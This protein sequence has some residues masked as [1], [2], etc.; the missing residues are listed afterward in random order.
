MKIKKGDNVILIA[1]KDQGKTG[2]VVKAMPK[3]SM[4]IVEGLNMRK[5]HE[6]ARRQGQKGQI[7]E[8]P[9]PM[10]VSNVMIVADGK[11]ARVGKKLVGESYVRINRKT[12]KTV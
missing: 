3:E 8:F 12:G 11:G 7:V 9:A 2:K 1:G 10:N 6:K 4:V 5:R